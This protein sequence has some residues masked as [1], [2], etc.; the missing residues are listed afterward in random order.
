MKDHRISG[1]PIVDVEGY[2]KGLISLENIIIALEEGRMD[3]SIE[4]H[5]VKEVVCLRDDMNVGSV[6]EYL[7]TYSYGRYPVLDD[8]GKVVGMVTNG[9]LI[10]IRISGIRFYFNKSRRIY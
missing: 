4:Q 8:E 6:I 3:D 1:I 10:E 9:D 2:L 5:M 7:M